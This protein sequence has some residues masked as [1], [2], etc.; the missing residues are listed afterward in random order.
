LIST[1][2][3]FVKHLIKDDAMLQQAKKNPEL[4]SLALT[5]EQ[6]KSNM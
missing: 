5:A 6:F 3:F 1:F 2:G 4:E